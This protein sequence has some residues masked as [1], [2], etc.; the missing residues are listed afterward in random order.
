MIVS[1]FDIIVSGFETKNQS[2]SD[3]LFNQRAHT[4][5]PVR[6]QKISCISTHPFM[7]SD[8][9]VSGRIIL[10]AKQRFKIILKKYIEIMR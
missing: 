7:R 9:F 3:N 8:D 5:L 10:V 4:S 6:G 1:G 2:A